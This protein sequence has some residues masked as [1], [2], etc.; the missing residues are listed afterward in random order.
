MKRIFR[1]S[2]AVAAVACASLP[3]SAIAQEQRCVSRA[4]SQAVVAH[5][6]PSLLTSVGNR[7]TSKLGS[8]SFL[9][10]QAGPLADR[11]TPLSH[12]S[13][14]AAKAALERQGGNTLPDNVAI[15]DFG[16]TAIADGIANGMDRDACEVVDQM[17]EQLAPLPPENLANVFSLFLE[18][19]INNDPKSAL[20]V[21]EVGDQ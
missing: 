6:M 14:P 3:A 16:R 12:R 4:E 7:C 1:T 5:L 21:C 15:L 10:T 2:M 20:R 13:W 18:S 9:A 17:L 19:G 11:M 8:R